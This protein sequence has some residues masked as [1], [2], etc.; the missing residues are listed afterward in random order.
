MSL[1]EGE[2]LDRQITSGGLPFPFIEN[3]LRQLASALDH[4]HDQGF[5][6]RDVKPGNV[7]VTPDSRVLL[8]DFGIA[9][10][11]RRCKPDHTCSWWGRPK[12]SAPKLSVVERDRPALG[13]LFDGVLAFEMVAGRP[14]FDGTNSVQVALQSIPRS[15]S[16]IW[17]QLREDV[18]RNCNRR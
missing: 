18:C 10:H 3:I 9:S 2:S 6:H 11:G 17:Q 14:P 12:Y 8:M 7:F 5:L 1:V 4:A 13:S 16:P 15:R